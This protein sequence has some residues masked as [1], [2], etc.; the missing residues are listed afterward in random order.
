MTAEPDHPAL[1]RFTIE[2][3]QLLLGGEPLW[4]LADR[5]GRTPFYAYE[6]GAMARRIVELRLSLPETVSLHYA[7][8][9]N[10]MPAVVNFLAP[11]VDG[12]DVAS[13]GELRTALDSGT[14]PERISIAGP[15]K[16]P[17]ELRAAV[18]AGVTV[19]VESPGELERLADMG[20]ETGVRPRAAVRVNPDFELKSSGMKMGGGPKQFGI[21]AEQVP[22]VLERLG[23]LDLHFRGFHVFGGSQNL[24]AENLVETQDATFDL[25]YRLADHAPG[26]VD[27]LNI[28]GGLGYPISPGSSPLTLPPVG[29]I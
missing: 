25:I 19:N 24:S 18:T 23:E 7:V 13:L 20:R 17:E 12:F 16:R 14:A 5:V 26:E 29:T 2:S 27:L 21:D 4:R 6:R 9:A 11:L 3:D 1:S 22:A 15:G 28:G 10:P 8:K